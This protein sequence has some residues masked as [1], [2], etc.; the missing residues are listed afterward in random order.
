MLLL[1]SFGIQAQ[2]VVVL[3]QASSSA[4]GAGSSGVPS[5]TI[6]VPDGDNRAIF[7]VS[8]FE[9]MHCTT[10][11][12]TSTTSGN[13]ADADQNRQMTINLAGPAS[14]GNFVNP[15]VLPDGDLRFMVLSKQFDPV[16]LGT[17]LSTET[18][19][20]AIYE[21]S[22]D[23]LLGGATSG[24]VTITLTEALAAAGLPA[25]AGDDT[26]LMAVVLENVNE[27]N[28]GIVRSATAQVSTS[29][30]PGNFTL[31]SGVFDAGQEVNDSKQGLVVFGNTFAGTPNTI[32]FNTMGG[33]TTLL[34]NQTSNTAGIMP[35]SPPQI[36][37]YNEGDGFTGTMQFRNGPTTGSITTFSLQANGSSAFD[38]HGG[39]AAAFTVDFAQAD[40]DIAK[41]LTTSDPV[42]GQNV[43]FQV[44]LDNFGPDNTD[45]VTVVDQLPSGYSFVSANTS[46]GSYSSGTGVWDIG[47]MAEG[48]TVTM[49]IVATVLPSGDYTNRAEVTN[50][51]V[52]DPDSTPSDTTG[53]DADEITINPSLDSDGDGVGDLV[54]IDDDNDGILDTQEL[55]GTDPQSPV[56]QTTI[57]IAINMDNFANEISWTLDG[58]SGQVGSGGGYGGAQNNTTVNETVNVTENGSYTFT[59]FDSW[60]DGLLGNTYSISGA[61]FT[62]ITDPFEDQGLTGTQISEQQF[63]TVTSISNSVFSCLVDDPNE[64]ADGD[65]TLNYQDADFCALNGAGVCDSLDTDGDGL[66]DSLDTDSD[67]DGCPD[68]I[69]GAGSFTLSDLDGDDSLG[70]TVD[71]NGVPTVAGATG[72]APTA[73]LTDAGDSS[74]CPTSTIDA[75]ADDFTGTPINGATGG[76]TASVF[77][78]NGNGVDDAN[79][80]PATNALIDDNISI[81]L[82]GGLTGVTINTDG[83]INIPGSTTGGTYNVTYQIC[84]TSDNTVCDTAVATIVVD[85][86]AVYTVDAAQNVDSYVANESLA[87]VSDAD[88]AITSAVLANA[89]TLPAGTQMDPVTGEITVSDP[90]LLVAGSY[91]VDITTVDATGGTTTQ[92]ITLT[93]DP[94]TEAVYTVDAA[95]N[96]DS[97]VANE[98]LATVSDADGAITSAVLA[99]ATTLPAGTQMDPVTGEITVSDPALLVAGSY[100]VDITTVDATGG[101]TTQ[102]ITLTFDPDTEAVY[103]VD[104]AQN[105]DSYVANESLATV[106]DADGA[107]TSAVLANATTLPAGTQM[108]PVTGEITVSDPALLVAGSYD[109]DITTVDATGGTTTQTITLTFD[110]DTE[111]VYTVDAAQNVDSYVANES[112]AT[113]SDADGAITSAVL[114]NGTTLPAGTQMDPVTGEITVS[115]PALLVAGSYDVDITTVDATGGTTTQTITLTFDPDT[116]AVYTVDAAQ[117]VDSYVANESLAT[118]SDADGAITSA[119]LANATTLPAGTQMDPVTGEITVSDPALLVAGS[120]DVDITTVDATGGTTTQTI[121]L[122]FDPDTEAVY[123]VDAAQNVDSYVANESLATVSDADGAITSAVLANGTTLPAGTQMD[124]VT[125]EITVSDP[126]LLVA[127]SYDVDI[128]TVDATGGTTTQTITLTFDP[129]TEAVYTV[130]AAQNVDSY[131]AN[132]SLATVSDADGAITSAVLANATTLPAGT[133]MDPVTG[134][135]T[136]SDPALLVAGSYDVDI[137]TVDATGGTTTQTITLTFDPDTEAVYTVDA[138]QNVDS[139]V[140]NE[141]LATVSDADGAITSAVLANATTLPAGTQMDPVT[142]EI[143]VS[144]PA[145]LVAGSYDVD[146]TT[147]D[148]TGGTTTQTITLTFDPDTEA[149]YTVDAAQNVD[150]YVANESLATVSDA[151][152]AITSA[153]LA[154]ATTLPAGTQM[155]PVTGEITVSDPALLVAG[156][157]DVDITTVDATGGTTTQTITLTFDPDTE[158]V[159]TVDAAQNVDSYVANES[160]ATV[161]DADGAITSAVL[162]NATTLPAGTQMDPVTGEI[163]VSDP[164]LLVAGSYDV[165]ITTVD[166]TGGT[167]TQTITLTFDPDTEAVYTVDAAQNVDSYVANES[168]ATVSDADGAITSAVLANATTLPAGTQ[169]DPV[170]GEI[171]VSDPALLVAGSYDVD[172]TTVDATGGTTTQTI[173]LTFDPDTEA[174]YTVDAAQN[175]DSY[176]ANESLATV[177]DADG[178]ITSAVLANATTLPAGTQMD[179]VT[180]E[181]TVSDPA[182]LVAGSYDVDITTV[183]ATGGTTTQT[184]TLTFDPDTEA[185]YTVDAAQNVDSYVANESLATVSDADGAITSAVL[186]NATTLPA[187]TQ[188]DPVTGEITVSDPALLV[189]GSYDV[190]ITTVDAT[191]GTTTQ[192]ITLTFDPDTE[193]VYTV[194]AAQNVDSYVANESLATVSDADGAITSAVLANATT[195][196]AGTQ[197]D[198]VTGEITVS[199]PALL[200]AGS[201]DVDITT[202]DATGGT[203]TQTITLTFD[204]D[205]EAVYTVDAAQNVDSY[206]ANES[207]A[208]VSDADGAITSAVLANATTLPAGTQMDPVTGEI[209]VSDPALLVA[210]SYDVDITTVDATGGTTT[211]TITLTF[212]PDTEAVYTV[213]AAQNVDSYVANESLATVS[214][215]DG[216]ITSA[217]LAN[218]TTLPA[219][220]QMDPVTGEITVSDP[221]LLVAGSYD[222]DITTVDATGGT[223]TQTI[224]LTFDPDTEAVY[225]VDAAQNVD[226]YVANESLAT[227]SDAD[228]AITSAVLANATTLPAGTQMDPVTGEITVSDP[229]LLV[230]GSYDVDITTVDATGGTTTQTITLTFDPDTEAVYTV[231]AAQNVDSY[232]ANESLATVSDADG[233]ITSAVLANATTLPAGTQMDPVTGEITVSDPA[234]LVAGSYDVDITTV[235]ATGGTTTQ[236][237]TLTFDPDTE[238]VY[239]VD[240]AQNVDS[241]VANE[242]L[243][244]VSDADGAITSAVLANATTLPAG[245]QMD[246]VTGEIT[247]SDPALLVAGSYDVDITTVDATGGTTTQTIT[248]TFDPDTEAVYT[249]DAAQN[250]DSYVASESLATVSDADGAI[251]SAV[252]AN[253]TTLPAGTQMDPVTGEI[254]VSD[255]ALLVAGSY[256]VDITTVDATGGTTTQTITLTFDPD[257]EAVYTVDAA[258]NVDSYVA[259]ESLATVSDADG[260]ITSAVLAN[261]TT[262][263]AGTQMDPV[264]GEIT[265]SDPALLVAGSYDVDITTVDA[266]GGTTT[267]TITLTFD[268][269]TEA[270]YTVDAAQNV[271]SYVAN[272]SLATVSDADGAIT[273]AVLANGTTLPAGTQMDPVTGEITVSDPALLVA[274]SYDVDITTVDATGGTTTQTITLTF[275]PDTEAV[276]TVDAAQNVDSYVA[277]E[278]LA[279]V[280][281]A[282]GAITSAVLANGTTLPAGTQMDPVTGEITVSDP[283]LLVA[284]SYDVDITTVDA[285][286]GT[287]TQTITLTFDPDV[288]PPTADSFVSEDITPT[289]TGS[290]YPN[291]I[292]SV[293]VDS[294]GDGNPEVTY[295]VQVDNT[296]M[297]SIDPDS[298]TPDSGTFPILSDGDSIDVTATDI[299]GNTSPIGEIIIE[300]DADND[301]LTDAEEALIGT[302]PNNPDTDGDGVGDAEEVADNTDPIDEC[303]YIIANQDLANVGDQWNNADCD[304]DGISNGQ[305]ILDGTD[306]LND[307][308]FIGGTPLPTSDCDNDGLTNEEEELLGTDIYNPDTDGD[309]VIDGQEVIDGTDPVVPCDFVEASTTLEPSGTYLTADCD[310]DGVLN[311]TE[312]T[313]GTDAHDPC[314]FLE[315]SI[316]LDQTGDYLLADCDQDGVTNGQEIADGTDLFDPCS[317]IGG[318]PPSGVV[319]DIEIANELITPDGDGINDVFR[320]RYIESYPDNTVEVFNRWGVNV[321]TT[322]GYDNNSNAFNGI[323]NG[324]VTIQAN[325]RL[326]AGVYFYIINYNDDGNSKSKSGYLYINQ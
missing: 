55:C 37:P 84:L 209:T 48:T 247:V 10:A 168:L 100:D 193:A 220:T 314:V 290:G 194:D 153:V 174:V 306:P 321:F 196:P 293:E 237:I 318:M 41:V 315:T 143:T 222:V 28:T 128:T 191:G 158:A 18:Y 235:D 33:Y 132:E 71:G 270:V 280:S 5:L 167:T 89:T 45:L 122:T 201:Y 182:L 215:A 173:T 51:S 207:L 198:P 164:A 47:Y 115:D 138:A 3:N 150:S 1:I 304:G 260:A 66:I 92:T 15:L 134:E 16:T 300:N 95:Q 264:T 156:S 61:D 272:E 219:G 238:A 241:Y 24:N 319:C 102:T 42:I 30:N 239:T 256:D 104:A 240:A 121:T 146:I 80:G 131:V 76:T 34:D 320:I 169:M 111:A 324:R 187:G 277:N 166:A 151:D 103:T 274:G 147:V 46:Q 275:D 2:N 309:G 273:S 284:G 269:D 245:T 96:V 50:S 285:T 108:D 162:A 234:L 82:D 117:N 223:T 218:G 35:N 23:G 65:G 291:E 4:T 141:S 73:A 21:S 94:D 305:E 298:V 236:T 58:P 8:M 172:I 69:E 227:V 232:V 25:S 19:H 98:S 185:V 154:N 205:T 283:A 157:Y 159:Y 299:F 9:R 170:T 286:G 64:D 99:N 68:A 216:A 60:G 278:S 53:D 107:I 52:T 282:D 155:D 192:T 81:T 91:D 14:S 152:G 77:A 112:L 44:T 181:I 148:A 208:T 288:T 252:L 6:N 133:Q 49:D 11:P 316:T 38:H 195:L 7:I 200:V 78:D 279:T 203:T 27:S 54:D 271:D 311:G 206:V 62:T 79:G 97:Y 221:A 179:P 86:E 276:Y 26:I 160:L 312:I 231:D 233:A 125:G 118:V 184:I 307:C 266:T 250:V 308:D 183:D 202:V 258:Q 116:E 126:A 135:I 313:D 287:T 136:V 149:V 323:S 114:A 36:L 296:G 175:V 144:D 163:T 297:W 317:A 199:D 106:S 63:F 127:G 211:Q 72:Q 294:D 67:N 246:P 124:P 190:D 56:T 74:A 301:G 109:V 57:S 83:T 263:P 292:I 142:G 326:P 268:P 249:V 267:Q 230:A 93:F 139:Y 322:N 119:V 262:L 29:P 253:G 225:T 248:L 90:A 161:S 257:T 229:A 70:D 110:P 123:T 171:T 177:S 85:T 105:V 281:D 43:T 228:G 130:D 180:G 224:T 325:D 295:T 212:D 12:C 39:Q 120:Y 213:D 214:D 302:D 59:I 255:P 186:A 165:D 137:T 244:T 32:G 243:A 31:A 88:G 145:L 189:A 40:L 261:A 303:D 87:T 129:D 242:S 13:F 113:V 197:M 204:P 22:I 265:V 178:A 176:V 140:A 251:T 210:G 101:T 217:V 254:T 188:M 310:G 259:N 75:M 289:L 17:Y 20:Y 226:S